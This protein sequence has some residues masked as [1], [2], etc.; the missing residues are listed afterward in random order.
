[1]I[2]EGYMDAIA[3][4]QYG[5]QNV[6]ASMGTALTQGQ[7]SLLKGLGQSFVLALDPDVAGQE[8]T[9]RSLES[10]WNVFQR[11]V[12]TKPR[13]V[14]MFDARG[15][16]SLRIARLPAGQDPDEFLHHSPEEWPVLIKQAVSLVDYVMQA[17]AARLDLNTPAG[18]AQ[19]VEVVFP[20]IAAMDNPYLQDEA[21]HKLA[22]LLGVDEA[23]L[24]A[25]IGRPRAGK[26]PRG[27]P[28][29]AEVSASALAS[30][31]GDPLEEHFLSLLLRFPQKK[32]ETEAISPEHFLRGENRE[33]F[34]SWIKCSTIEEL[35]G[36]L[37][38]NLVEHAQRLRNRELPPA[39]GKEMEQA[40]LDCIHRLE[41]RRLRDIEQALTAEV[42]E[43]DE[44]TREQL[45]QANRK[46]T[47]IFG[48]RL[49]SKQGEGDER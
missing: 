21:F 30:A 5:Y 45:I 10:A 38:R 33:I 2:V 14:S 18:K 11:N 34:T 19:C 42:L 12:V 46:L 27:T 4:H 32:I 40:F 16:A 47:Q 41:E 35:E 3:A 17:L 24:K 48:S 49:A 25:G 44:S 26:E 31:Q 20:L 1:V 13:G 37:D 28:R 29:K 39:T 23:T 7:V 9:L 8:A 6:V 15:Q 22:G 36:N 43:A